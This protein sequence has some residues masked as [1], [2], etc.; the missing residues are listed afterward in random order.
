MPTALRQAQARPTGSSPPGDTY[1]TRLF[2]APGV[3]VGEAGRRSR[4][5]TATGRTVGALPAHRASGRLHLTGT[6]RAAAPR[7]L[8]RGRSRTSRSG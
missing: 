8:A 3:G 7:Q 6:I 1:R 2:I 5:F 4:A